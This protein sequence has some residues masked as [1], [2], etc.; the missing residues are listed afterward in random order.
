VNAGPAPLDVLIPTFRR[1]AA[2]G[3][4]LAALAAQS[5]RPFRL[6]V[7]D[8]TDD[9][10]PAFDA[11]EVQSVLGVLELTGRTVELHRHLPRRGMAEHREF[12][13]SRVRAPYALFLD[14]DVVCEGDLLSRLLRAIR[15]AGCGFVGAGLIG[16]SFADDRRPH[17]QPFEPWP[18][19]RV[20]PEPVEPGSDAWERH[21]LHNAA[22][23]HHLRERLEAETGRRPDDTL[24]KVAWV[25]GCVL[26]D[27]AKLR[28]VGG[29]SF[30][31]DLPE[32]HAGEDVL[33]QLRLMRRHGGAGLFPSGAYHLELPTTIPH[34][35]VDAPRVL[36]A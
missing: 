11:P 24:Y 17:E 5:L 20:R 23:L 32:E 14:D 16:P 25:G 27:T 26:Y 2:L 9:R 8:Q 28:E 13:L 34:R 10:E 33:A 7:S 21:R 31:R 15:D 36:R 6:V 4:T 3:A 19:N 22:N 35:E 18:G 30:W 29:F 12:L 1:P